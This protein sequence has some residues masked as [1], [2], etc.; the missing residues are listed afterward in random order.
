MQFDYIIVGA[1]SAGCVL[2]ARLSE[3]PDVT[4]CLIEAGGG[5][6]SPL[7]RTPAGAAVMLPY[8]LN[9]WGFETLPQPGLNGRRG[10]Q[11]R[12]KALGGSS[13]INAMIYARGRATDYDAW[14]RDY[15][16]TGWSW[17]D[18]LPYFRRSE[19]NQRFDDPAHGRDGPMHVMDIRDPNPF[20]AVF[21]KAAAE[22]GF[23]VVDD[24]N[25]GDH[26][27]VGYYQVTQKDG[28]R[29]SAAHAYLFPAMARDN[30]TV[31]TGALAQRILFSGRRAA[32]VQIEREGRSEVLRADQEVLVCAG[33][34]QSPQLL[35]CSG[36]GPKEHLLKF[37]IL[38]IADVPGVGANLEDHVR[39]IV[40][41]RCP[42]LDLYGISIGGVA[43]MASEF[44]RY[45]RDKRGMLA[46]NLAETGGFIKT[47]PDLAEPDI[48][49]HFVLGMV[50]NH[51]RTLHLG[52]G[53]S[54]HACL[55]KPHSRGTV[56][57]GSADMRDAPLIDPC[58][59]SALED[60][61]TLTRAFTLMRRILDAPA[62]ARFRGVELYTQALADDDATGIQAAIRERGDSVY[63]PSS[64]C[65][66]GVDETAVLDLELRV[67]GVS[68]LRVVDA[69]A[70]PELIAANTSAAVIMMAEKAADLIKKS[71]VAA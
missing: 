27:G 70:M 22:A 15:G 36:V 62:F 63:H 47:H 11:P 39:Y 6:N 3:D 57:L 19:C 14:A 34:L 71:R 32:G 58:F 26:E 17:D 8:K 61:E 51:N 59:F 43:R 50:D 23:A 30:L 5:G 37:G 41:R 16:C 52:H 35:M 29:V 13:A 33:A 2:A 31:I 7:V 66:M 25:R 49:L 1:G 42:S 28:Q 69:S 65:R 10:Y 18:V 4:V 9:N 55:L 44:L 67:R 12:G 46:S 45:R 20:G 24:F 68:A 40:N 64:T 53:Y 54:L 60:I 56:R 21:L 38:P 48:Q